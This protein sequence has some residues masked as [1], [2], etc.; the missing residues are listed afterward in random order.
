MEFDNLDSY[1]RSD[2]L[3]TRGQALA[4][5]KLLVARAH[6]AGLA[7]GQKNL[8]D[9]DGTTIGYDFAV[10]EE[11]GRYRECDQ[12]VASFGD[13]VLMIEYR[14]QDFA[15]TCA[16]YGATHA[17]VLRNRNLTPAGVHQYC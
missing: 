5:A 8:S 13:Q 3:L 12:Y 2:D 10:S 6:Q 4:Y 7:A 15:K 14:T 17:V 16:A 11:C 1:T 9:F